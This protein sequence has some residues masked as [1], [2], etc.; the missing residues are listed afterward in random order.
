PAGVYLSQAS[1]ILSCSSSPKRSHASDVEFV[2]HYAVM[3]LDN[4]ATSEEIKAVYRRLRGEYF[5]SNNVIKYRALQAAFDVLADRDARWAYDKIWR[6]R[7]GLPI[8]PPLKSQDSVQKAR[9]R[10]NVSVAEPPAPALVEV[11]MEVEVKEAEAETEAV[12]VVYGPLIG[13]RPYHSYIPLLE[14][15]DGRD[16]HPK[17][18]CGRPKY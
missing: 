5:G 18:K 17:L 16:V 12:T 6:A 11:E 7:K 14:V 10:V 2:D 1:A 9:D 13:T 15:Y 4:W 3:E 8:P